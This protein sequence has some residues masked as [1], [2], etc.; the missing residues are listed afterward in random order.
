[1]G[2]VAVF[3]TDRKLKD[4][5]KQDLS[6]PEYIVDE[7]WDKE[8]ILEQISNNNY[9]WILLDSRAIAGDLDIISMLREIGTQKM[10]WLT[11]EENIAGAR[12]AIQRGA[13]FYLTLPLKLDIFKQVFKEWE[14][15]SVN[16]SMIYHKDRYQPKRLKVLI[17]FLKTSL[18]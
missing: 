3:S 8:M 4:Q 10:L 16:F 13:D 2:K 7:I 6:H 9:K 15:P 14:I 17:E 12:E 11:P 5:L 18:K 1:M